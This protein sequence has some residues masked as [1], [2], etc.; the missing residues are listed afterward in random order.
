M[1]TG[2]TDLNVRAVA[3]SPSYT[4]DHTLF[5]GTRDGVFKSTDGGASWNRMITGFT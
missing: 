2:L 3:L 4:A 1:N 5:A